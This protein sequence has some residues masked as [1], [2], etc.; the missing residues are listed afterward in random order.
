M[1][2]GAGHVRT[3]LCVNNIIIM[4]IDLVHNIFTRN[5]YYSIDKKIDN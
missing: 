1:R 5:I 2:H 4:F 3:P